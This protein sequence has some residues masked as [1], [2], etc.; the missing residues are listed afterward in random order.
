MGW[1]GVVPDAIVWIVTTR[2]EWSP[3]LPAVACLGSLS[4][5]KVRCYKA[6]RARPGPRRDVRDCIREQ[7]MVKKKKPDV[8]QDP[9]APEDDV[10]VEVDAEVQSATD[11]VKTAREQLRAAEAL[12]EKARQKAVEKV[13][14]LQ[15]KSTGELIDSSLDFV[16]KH[17]C[18]GV[19]AAATIG[20][21]LGRLFRR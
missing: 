5:S 10:D 13:T 3:A 7:I 14:Q 20:F 2:L 4:F 21:F 18:L 8:S 9:P 15:D 6:F 11:Q 1:S 12:L 19:F 17:P 16:R